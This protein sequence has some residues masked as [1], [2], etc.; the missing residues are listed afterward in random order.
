MELINKIQGAVFFVDILGF[1]ELTQKKITLKNEDFS[2]WLD[3]Y[4]L[5]YEN[6]NLAASILAKFREILL[7]VDEK[8]EDVTTSQ[9]SDCAFV[10]SK[11]IKEVIISANNIMSECISNGVLCRGGL[12][13]GEIIETSQNHKLGRFILGD[14]VTNAVKLEG[15]AKG[16]RIMIHQ[17]FLFLVYVLS[18][19]ISK[20]LF[21][22]IGGF[23]TLEA[24]LKILF[25]T[26]VLL[27]SSSLLMPVMLT[28]S[29]FNF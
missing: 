22:G 10:W 25:N 27:I 26:V 4:S 1:G 17:E 11:N 3:Q 15:I 7:K 13:Y 8:F 6:Q 28:L 23:T 19:P 24:M 16:C 18:S 5:E 9:L 29:L 14:A 2:A 12:S 21:F 20:V